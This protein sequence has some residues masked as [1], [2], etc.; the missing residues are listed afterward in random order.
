MVFTLGINGTVQR[1]TSGAT[2]SKGYGACTITAVKQPKGKA[3]VLVAVHFNGD[4]K[5][6]KYDYAS[7]KTS[8]VITVKK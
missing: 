6:P 7:A 5:G 4:S 8:T 1:C 2:N 3:L